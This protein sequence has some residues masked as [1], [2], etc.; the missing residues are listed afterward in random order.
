MENTADTVQ[1]FWRS[2]AHG[3]ASNPEIGIFRA[4]KLF[5]ETDDKEQNNLEL[6][7]PELDMAGK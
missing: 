1:A 4:V 5:Y 7:M 6:E 3:K 2:R